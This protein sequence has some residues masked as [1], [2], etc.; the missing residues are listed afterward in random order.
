MERTERFYK[1]CRRLGQGGVIP[2]KKFIEEFG[3]SRPT[4]FRD[5]EYLQDRFN[6]PIIYDRQGG[7]YRF[8]PAAAQFTLP[9]IWFTAAEVESL[10][11]IYKMLNDIQPGLLSKHLSPVLDRISRLLQQR[12]S[13]LDEI[14]NR[15]RIL[16]IA[17]R[18]VAA[19]YFELISHAVLERKRVQFAHYHR[20]RD[21]TTQRQVSP[22]RLVHYRDNWYLDSYDHGREALR[23]FSLDT[24]DDLKVIEQKA[25]N[26]SNKQLDNELGSSYGIFAGQTTQIAILKFTSYQA[27]WVAREHWHPQQ[28]GEVQ[29][30]GSYLLQIP[31]HDPRELLMDI[32]KYGAQVEVLKPKTLREEVKTRLEQAAK[33]YTK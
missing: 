2:S 11:T 1:I 25:K 26:I 8:D 6:A 18:T 23:T 30:D 28:Q 16:S 24:I 21:E 7:G 29:A 9:G 33:L 3:I 4:F 15:I 20:E 17:N 12:N 22:Q 27:R 31:Y 13:T 5:I 10:L 19:N 14:R 32:L